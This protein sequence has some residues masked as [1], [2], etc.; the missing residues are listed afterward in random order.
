[1]ETTILLIRH[2]FINLADKIPGRLPDIHLSESGKMQVQQLIKLVSKYKVDHIYSSPL[3]R[4]V[5]TA[6]PLAN[7]F[8][9]K[10]NMCNSISEIDF[11]IWTNKTFSDL[12]Q[13][14]QWKQFHYFRTGT[15]IPD[16][17]TMIDVQLRMI[18][19]MNAF[20]QQHPGE[21]ILVVSHNDPV[22]SIIAYY[23]GISLDLFLRIS[24]PNASVSVLS[25]FDESVLVRCI[26]VTN[27]IDPESVQ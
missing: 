13:V 7:Y 24:I 14:S 4:A 5:E 17:E 1:M 16:G 26:G 19:Q 18:Q 6:L 25:M 11:G 27:T 10:I 23:L 15:K 22:K 3:D 20:H 2:G 9:R 21:T 12:E 8:N